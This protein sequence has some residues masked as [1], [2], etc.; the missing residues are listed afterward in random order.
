MGDFQRYSWDS[1]PTIDLTGIEPDIA[2]C[3]TI[4]NITCGRND[5]VISDCN[6]VD[7]FYRS[8]DIQPHLVY[9]VEVIPRSNVES[10]RNGTPLSV[11][12]K[13]VFFVVNRRDSSSCNTETFRDINIELASTRFEKNDNSDNLTVALKVDPNMMVMTCACICVLDIIY[14]R[15]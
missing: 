3:I 2:Y 11:Y 12:G 1:P 4:H 13:F 7:T 14:L 10:A 15:V 8:Q 9:G 6:I 5:L